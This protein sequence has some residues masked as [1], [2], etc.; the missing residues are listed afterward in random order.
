MKTAIL[1]DIHANLQALTACLAHARRQGA[2]TFAF[3]GDLVGYGA[4]PHACLAMVRGLAAEGAIVVRGN[5]DE[6]AL[7]GLCGDLGFV[8]REAAVWT[9]GQIDEDDRAF[10]AAL[11]HAA[12]RA[13]ALFVHASADRPER[14]EYI[15]GTPAAERCLAATD[16]RV[17][18]AGHGHHAM[19]Y[20]S[21]RGRLT[22]F[23]PRPGVAVPLSAGRRWL[24][25]AGSVG[26]PRDGNPAACYLLFD[27]VS[28]RL[29][30]HRVAYDWL[31][32]A[33]RIRAAGLPEALAHRLEHGR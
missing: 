9:R 18:F 29:T 5:H 15:T 19:L 17:V 21:A 33:A 2:D 23:L 31:T 1:S 11:P 25:L 6:A 13:G 28:R 20:F 14:W 8:A 16:A 4:D 3:T 32:A 10:L 27:G 24:A 12:E 22:A 7:G 26:Q 30:F